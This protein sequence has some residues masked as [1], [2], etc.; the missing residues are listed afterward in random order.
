MERKYSAR[1]LDD[2]DTSRDACLYKEDRQADGYRMLTFA[3]ILTELFT[4]LFRKK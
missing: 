3:Y 4:E 1:E 2:E